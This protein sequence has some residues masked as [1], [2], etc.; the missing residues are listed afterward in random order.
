MEMN[1]NEWNLSNLVWE[2]HGENE[3]ESFLWQYYY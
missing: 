1:E 3:M 2:Q